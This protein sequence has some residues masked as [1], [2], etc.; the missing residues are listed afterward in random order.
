MIFS[1][2]LNTEEISATYFNTALRLDKDFNNLVDGNYSYAAY[3][4][5]SGGN[6]TISYRNFS[7]DTVYP[8][9]PSPVISSIDGTDSNTSDL[10][11]SAIMTHEIGNSMNVTV[12]WYRNDISNLTLFYNN[13][14]SNGTLF[15][16]ILNA[17]PIEFNLDP[18][19]VDAQDFSIYYEDGWYHIYYIKSNEGETWTDRGNNSQFFGYEKSQDLSH[20]SFIDN[21]LE[22]DNT[23]NWNNQHVWAPHVFKN[24]STYYM[25]YAGIDNQT[26]GAHTERIGLATSTN[27]Q[28]WTRSNTNNCSGTIGDGCVWDCNT[29]WGGWDGGFEWDGQCRDPYVLD[30]VADTGYYYMVYT[31]ITLQYVQVV[32]LAKSTDL[33]NWED[34]G[35]IN[36]TSSG[37]AE[38]PHILK[39]NNTYYI[40]YSSP[41]VVKYTS[42]TNITDLTL[43]NWES[44]VNVPGRSSAYFASE[45]LND[46]SKLVWADISGFEIYF[47][48]FKLNDTSNT[49][50]LSNLNSSL[51][52]GKTNNEE[53]WSCKI[54]LFS[55][56]QSSAWG[57]SSNLL[58]GGSSSEVAPQPSSSSTYI[59]QQTSRDGSLSFYV[60]IS[61][62]KESEIQIDDNNE[63]KVTNLKIKAKNRIRGNIEI[64]KSN[65]DEVDCKIPEEQ[66][67][68][69]FIYNVL[70][71]SHENIPDEDIEEVKLTLEVQKEWIFSNN[72]SQLEVMRCKDSI[73]YLNI[74]LQEDS[75]KNKKYLVS[76]D[77]FSKWIIAGFR[78]KLLPEIE[79]ENNTIVEKEIETKAEETKKES[80]SPNVYVLSFVLLGILLL[81]IKLIIIP[82]KNK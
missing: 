1:R 49:M 24:G 76:S 36:R 75:E 64:K 61:R 79:E 5:N 19:G 6:L 70:D 29:T 41:S 27:L 7:K 77:G 15:S 26:G 38:S 28:D 31:T 72:I 73:E 47:M 16:S 37:K 34:V 18:P 17:T 45:L 40:F 4:I 59:R 30:D 3:A 67:K 52:A 58:I 65:M 50:S 21:V 44:L 25:Y 81:I 12:D 74:S 63:T 2:A 55:G 42:T 22:V 35:P 33:I 78:E 48:E 46:S 56:G 14:Y 23:S 43:S 51:V 9:T 68:E 66:N 53:N 80:I 8:L 57:N 71:I 69:Y 39:Q 11:C 82:K 10:N 32:G 62:G 54:K 13:E 60:R 20:W